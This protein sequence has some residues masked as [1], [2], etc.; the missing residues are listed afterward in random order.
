M[1]KEVSNVDKGSKAKLPEAEITPDATEHAKETTGLELRV[2]NVFNQTVSFEAI[3]NFV[4]GIGDCNPLYRERDYARTTVYG[5]LIAPPNWL[6]SVF[7]TW[8]SEGF[9]GVHGFHSGNDWEFYKPIY[10]GDYI[11]PKCINVGFDVIQGQFGGKQIWKYQRS[12]FYNQR[13]ELVA[14]TYMWSLR[15]ERRA[16]R[17][18]G[19]YLQIELPH[20]WK[21]EELAAIEESVM[22]ERVRGGEV[23]YW[24]DVDIGEE[25]PAIIKGPLGLTDIVAM[26]AGLSP[27]K[28]AA[29]RAMLDVY[30]RHP[31]WAFRDPETFALEPIYAVHYNK[32]AA[33]AAGLPQ[34]YDVGH[35]RQCWLIQSITDW[36]GDEGWLKRNYAEYRRFVY[37][38]D[39]VSIQGV[40]SAKYID[41]NG[42]ACVDVKTHAIN[43]RGEDAAVAFSTVILPSRERATWPVRER[44]RHLQ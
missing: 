38:S 43:Q 32:Q 11:T 12:E 2:N 30:R 22:A 9:A 29:H 13:E 27:I 19:K 41:D 20:P 24:E 34:A 25:L 7:P 1:D 33:L 17:K 4:N 3:R 39:A 10:L 35:Q 18:R 6:Y 21:D 5:E 37:L 44:A 23:Q 15:A 42:E 31:A 16:A 28:I 36:M 26:C 8:V 40:V 14:R